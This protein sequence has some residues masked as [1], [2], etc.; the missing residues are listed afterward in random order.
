M[1]S[2][3]LLNYTLIVQNSGSMLSQSI[4]LVMFYVRYSSVDI[5][6]TRLWFP[7][8]AFVFRHQLSL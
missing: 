3:R 7:L 8:P 6:F 2:F 1:S 5:K 4:F